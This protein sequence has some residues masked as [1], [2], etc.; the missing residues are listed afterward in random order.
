MYD[1][2]TNIRFRSVDEA[3]EFLNKIKKGNPINGWKKKVISADVD[4]VRIKN[5]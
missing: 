4:F 1:T 3:E 2:S 5:K